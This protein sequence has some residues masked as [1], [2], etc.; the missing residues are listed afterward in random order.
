M[1]LGIDIDDTICDSWL[2]IA[3][4]MCKDFNLDYNKI[5]Q[6]KK[7]YR[8]IAYMT[9]EQ[10]RDYSKKFKQL[11]RSVKLKKDVKEIIDE[12]SKENKIIFITARPDYSFDNAYLFTKK[13]L[14]ENNI[15]YDKIIVNGENKKQICAKENIDI[16]IDDSKNNC[17]SVSELGIKVLMYENYFN[18]DETR[19]K[20]VNNWKEILKEVNNARKIDY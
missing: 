14:D 20:K 8:D 17:E 3:P 6:S 18:E 2:T 16:F 13:F 1:I 19:F 9:D 11:L 4:T 12:L 15:Y 10:Y 5:L 7:T